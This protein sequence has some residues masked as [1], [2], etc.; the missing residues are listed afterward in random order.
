MG[1]GTFG[2]VFRIIRKKDGKQLA[3]K[4]VFQDRKFKNREKGIFSSLDHMNVPILYDTYY[5]MK[6][7]VSMAKPRTVF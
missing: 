1:E 2:K 7:Q 3:L 5:T 6:D 4:S